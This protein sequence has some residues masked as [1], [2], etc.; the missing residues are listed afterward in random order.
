MI[1]STDI[2]HLHFFTVMAT[3]VKNSVR[4]Q[5][6]D[7]YTSNYSIST[8]AERQREASFQTRQE[9]RFL[10]NETDSKTK[11][12]QYDNTTRLAD[13]VDDIRKWKENLEK[14]LADLDKEVGH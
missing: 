7:W 9:A 2:Q 10:S 4:F 13:R 11:W 1:Y 8:N 14:C 12:D 6:A 5:P 3:H